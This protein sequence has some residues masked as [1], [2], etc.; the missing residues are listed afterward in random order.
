MKVLALTRYSALGAS[1][2]VR[3][4][5]FVEALHGHGVNVTVAPLLD[6]LYLR[7]LY[8]KQPL[9]YTH[10]MR[11]YAERVRGMRRAKQYDVVWFEKEML[12]WVPA[13]VERALLGNLPYVV[14]Y[15]DATFHSYDRHPNPLVRRTMGQKIDAI[16]ARARTVVVGNDY[17]GNRAR[18]AGAAHVEWV[19]SV[20]PFAKYWPVDP[21]TEDRPFVVGWI[22][23]PGS[24]HLLESARTVLAELAAT[25]NTIVRL[26]GAN[27]DALPGIPHETRPWSEAGEVDEIRQLSVG[28]MPVPDTPWNRGKCGYKLVQYLAAGVP[29]VASPLG[30]NRTIVRHGENGFWADTAEQWRDALQALRQNP[31]R[32]FEMGSVGR[33]DIR[34]TYTVEAQVPRLA[35]LL[36][37]AAR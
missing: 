35:E 26:I 28:I 24:Q 16:M 7:R 9:S 15:D 30:I 31:Q 23:S 36:A 32:A 12:P 4:Y 14:D 13:R 20:V 27:A 11:R 5:Q 33:D 3:T 25:P 29:V 22:G 37:Q 8:A 21:P 10:V 18:A 2:R 17:L 19:P 6:D 34:K 1:S